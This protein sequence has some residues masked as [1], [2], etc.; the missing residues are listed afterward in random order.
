[1]F[2]VANAAAKNHFLDFTKKYALDYKT[3]AIK[4]K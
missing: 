1:M 2:L 3:K 4:I